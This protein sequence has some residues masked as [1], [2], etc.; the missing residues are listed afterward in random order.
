MRKTRAWKT[1]SGTTSATP[2]E[3]T[4]L[5]ASS[6][7][8]RTAIFKAAGLVDGAGGNSNDIQIGPN[9]DANYYP[10]VAGQEYGLP[11]L[12]MPNESIDLYDWYCQSAGASQNYI[13]LYLE[14]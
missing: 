13:I 6:L 7:T 12:K 8:V 10:V 1:I 4:R 2:D 14:H 3:A 9:S 11:D 5:V